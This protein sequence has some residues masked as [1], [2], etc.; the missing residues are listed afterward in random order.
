MGFI[1]E[2]MYRDTSSK[3]RTVLRA[4]HL[5]I[6]PPNSRFYRELLITSVFIQK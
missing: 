2:W 1:V 6:G 5:L 3:A 4:I